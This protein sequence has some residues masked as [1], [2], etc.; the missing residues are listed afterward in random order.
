MAM[1]LM[2][3]CVL[4]LTGC[5][6]TSAP[7][8]A[9]LSNEELK[10]R[11]QH[12]TI[13]VRPITR[14]AKLV[15]RTKSQVVGNFLISSLVSSAMMSNSGARTPSEF[16][17]N[18]QIGQQF[19]QG[20]NSALPTTRETDAGHGV[21]AFL[22]NRLSERFPTPSSSPEAEAI[23]LVVSMLQWELSY[24]S[25]TGSDAYVLNSG[26]E[27]RAIDTGSSDHRTLRSHRC[28]EKF[29][30]TMA[31]DAWHA[32]NDAAI[33][34]AADTLSEKCYRTALMALGID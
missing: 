21:D 8:V 22:V 19:G 30:E 7:R 6:T 26:V 3:L 25:F 10:E 17:A 11:L 34:R 12:S 24:E 4:V 33:S 13:V 14:P 9:E 2:L 28:T 5:A 18:T 23:E 16:Q 29:T 27:V 32:D 1:R 20:L 15:E 31:L